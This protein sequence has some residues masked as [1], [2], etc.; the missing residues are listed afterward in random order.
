M[1]VA[2]HTFRDASEMAAWIGIDGAFVDVGYWTTAVSIQML[3]V[4]RIRYRRTFAIVEIYAHQNPSF[5]SEGVQG[6]A[7]P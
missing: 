2:D 7:V 5:G 6:T 3:I 4:I 1:V